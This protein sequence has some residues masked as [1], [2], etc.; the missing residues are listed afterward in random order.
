[1]NGLNNCSWIQHS[2][3]KSRSAGRPSYNFMKKPNLLPSEIKF[4]TST[5]LFSPKLITTFGSISFAF[6]YERTKSARIFWSSCDVLFIRVNS[7]SVLSDDIL[8][9]NIFGASYAPIMFLKKL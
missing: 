6:K 4:I 1:M 2:K 8:D 3:Y 7:N 5:I 9:I